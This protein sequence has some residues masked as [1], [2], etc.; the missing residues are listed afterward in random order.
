M[1][2]RHFG[3]SL[4][5]CLTVLSGPAHAQQL[6]DGTTVRV[7]LVATDPGVRK[8]SLEVRGFDVLWAD[9]AHTAIDLIVT[10]G[11]WR[12]LQ[13][14]G[15]QGRIVDR[16]RPLRG[17][18]GRTHRVT[19]A[20]PAK[21]SRVDGA[22]VTA[23]AIAAVPLNE[24]GYSDLAG[25]LASMQAIADLYPAIARFVDVTATYGAPA[26][27]EG[28]HLYAL[29][30]SDNAAVDE[31][32]P[33]M[34]IVAAHHAREISTPVIALRAAER[35]T[36]QYGIDPEVTAAVDGNEI[37]IAPLW[38]PDGYNHVFTTDNMWRKNRRLFGGGVGV[39]LNR[40]FPPGY[41]APCAGSTSVASE[42]YKGPSALSEAETQT[43]QVWSRAER[44][45]KVIDYHSYGREVLYGYVCLA[46]PFQTWM[47]NEATAISNASGY[48]GLTRVPS[49]EGEHQQWQF[50]RQGAYAFLIETHT[51]FQ[52]PFASAVA[53]A[54]AV[55]PGILAVLERPISISGHVTDAVTG[56]PLEASITLDNVPFGNGEAY[57]SGGQYGAYAMVLPPGMY[58]VRFTVPG[59][60]SV[61][62]PVVVGAA[63]ATTLDVPL[64]VEQVVFADSFDTDTGWLR[65]AAGTDTATSG[66]WERGVSQAT[67]LGGAKQLAPASAGGDLSTGRLAGLNANANDVD[68]GLTSMLSPEIPLP[69][70]SPAELRFSYYFAHAADSSSAD[71]FR[72]TIVTDTSTTIVLQELGSPLNDNAAWAKAAISLQPFMGQTIRILIEAADGSTA[73]LVEAAVDDLKVVKR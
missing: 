24:P 7:R 50:A 18:D 3:T 27:A 44:F 64:T 58:A 16:G 61:V 25:I 48:G 66:L 31:D 13:H 38:N 4:V 17:E 2:C 11:E 15:W 5:V 57:G 12:E 41:S 56:A 59:Y 10:A 49:N 70:D 62:N 14:E 73:S 68:G 45:A 46:Y 9:A 40:N 6:G 8:Q 29:K 42:T 51:E 30:I 36:S 69:A 28:R 67:S 1:T 47:R 32:E 60:N 20:P 71:A 34:L 52:P 23:A 35:F 55:W 43:M 33:A 37:W 39:D 53:E 63:T 22:A 21:P 72:V 65:N 19:S 54:D 26:T